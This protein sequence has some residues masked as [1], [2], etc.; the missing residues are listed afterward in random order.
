[1]KVALVNKNPAVSRLITLSLNKIGTE[2]VQLEEASELE[3]VFDFIIIDSDIDTT[4]IDIG[5]YSQ[6]IMYLAP[7]NSDVPEY[8]T[9]TL[10]KPFLPTDF[11]NVFEQN[12]PNDSIITNSDISGSVFADEISTDFDLELPDFDTELKSLDEDV[13]EN[14]DQLSQELEESMAEIENLDDDIKE[15]N[16]NEDKNPNNDIKEQDDAINEMLSGLDDLPEL[17]EPISSISS[18]P[19]QIKEDV[20]FD[21]FN[22]DDIANAR[23]EE[24]F[25][26]EIENEELLDNNADLNDENLE[27]D[28]AKAT[29]F[30][31][32]EDLVNEIDE[33]SK[34]DLGEASSDDL[35][36]SEVGDLEVDSIE[37]L[38][39]I[40]DDIDAMGIDE[41][42]ERDDEIADLQ[43]INL[44]ESINEISE[45]E[46][47]ESEILEKN[48]SESIGDTDE[49]MLEEV[50]D[51]QQN[52]DTKEILDEL[53]VGDNL[54]E[55]EEA[56]TKD[57]QDVQGEVL[58]TLDEQELTL[59]KED[60]SLL[61]DDG[62]QDILKADLQMDSASEDVVE[63][64]SGDIK[65]IDDIDEN[66]M[67]AAFGLSDVKMVLDSVSETEIK[68][69]KNVDFKDELSK[70]ISEHITSSLNESSIKDV[71]KDMNIKINISFEEK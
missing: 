9:A 32:L 37:N 38:E 23:D 48:E 1:M 36:F 19:L 25:A 13:D 66:S 61:V 31:E 6:N 26:K 67:M 71:L 60:E 21:E 52:E 18:R 69:D 47:G 68:N 15:P 44:D 43:D 53:S 55:N 45:I 20:G 35:S 17:D 56:L 49:M 30:D 41:K 65:N 12:K 63:I 2:Y 33:I 59:D 24:G 70:K 39:Q 22:L 10:N 42:N 62:M 28:V 8:A 29:D 27:A 40:I 50:A 58:N 16:L 5:A 46:T 34:D 11:I 64:A 7:R 14:L 54:Q 51:T 4:D 57:L 3:G